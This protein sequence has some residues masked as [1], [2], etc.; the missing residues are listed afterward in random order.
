VPISQPRPIFPLAP[1]A[2]AQDSHP[3][4]DAT[5]SIVADYGVPCIPTMPPLIAVGSGPGPFGSVVDPGLVDP[6]L[7][8]SGL[9]VHDRSKLQVAA[10]GELGAHG[11]GPMLR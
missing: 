11:A 1:L 9:V 3:P 2:S 8:G 5:G 10:L 6:G 4:G 7:V